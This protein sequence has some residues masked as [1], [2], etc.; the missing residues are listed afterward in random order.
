MTM[1]VL[2]E[3]YETRV[4]DAD[5]IQ[6]GLREIVV[7]EDGSEHVGGYLAARTVARDGAPALYERMSGTLAPV[8][9]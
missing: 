2:V 7:Q 5:T 6:I 1:E 8:T 9:P 4:V 3:V